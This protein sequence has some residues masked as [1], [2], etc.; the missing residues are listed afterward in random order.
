MSGVGFIKGICLYPGTLYGSSGSFAV[1]ELIPVRSLGRRV[2]SGS[3][4][5]SLCALG[6]IQ[7]L[8]VHSG[9]P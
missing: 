5:P 6:V 9:V 3:L 1:S 2:H 4:G 7:V 8:S